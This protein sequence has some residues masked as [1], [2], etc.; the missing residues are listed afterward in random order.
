MAHHLID[1]SHAF[2][3]VFNQITQTNRVIKV[4]LPAL[5]AAIHTNWD[6][7]LLAD[8]A[9]KAATLISRS[10]MGEGISE[11]VELG[12]GEKLWGHI[13]L[14]PEN[15]GNFHFD[16]HFAS[17]VSEE[18]VTC[19][20]DELGL[21]DR[22]VVEPQ[23]DIAVIAVVLEVRAGNG[24]RF[25]GVGREDGQRA[26]GVKAN[27]F[28]GVG[29][30]LGF[31]DY[32]ANTFTYALPN[33]C[34]RLL[35]VASLRLPQLNVLCSEGFDVARFVN[36]A[37]AG[38]ACPDI[39]SNVMV[40]VC[41]DQSCAALPLR[42]LGFLTAAPNGGT[43]EG[44]LYEGV[45]PASLEVCCEILGQFPYWLDKGEDEWSQYI[46]HWVDRLIVGVHGGSFGA[47]R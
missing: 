38:G 20:V 16:A 37:G 6:E 30:D 4:F 10:D 23:N 45:L 47:I 13:I 32:P 3:I 31:A 44:Q 33:V 27:A 14:E 39:D 17:D 5:D 15:L 8:G 42:A 29:V 19:I 24:N 21:R 11:I 46:L 9:A 22:S 34:R 28:N 43:P 41:H 7:T 1:A 35:V 26:S 36:D 40:L 12:S 2:K 25:V 18:I